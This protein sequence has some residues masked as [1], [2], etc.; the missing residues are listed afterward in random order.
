M[1]SNKTKSVM[2]I[3]S[4]TTTYVARI[5]SSTY[6]ASSAFSKDVVKHKTTLDAL[7][8]LN[9]LEMS[10][11]IVNDLSKTTCTRASTVYA[12]LSYDMK[13]VYYPVWKTS[14]YTFAI[15]W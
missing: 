14:V 7:S 4:Q 9:I 2:S 11:G 3:A 6:A 8:M 5:G 12:M 10:S 13:L 1:Y 15:F